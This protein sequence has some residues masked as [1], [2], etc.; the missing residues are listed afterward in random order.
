M[1]KQSSKYILLSIVVSS[2]SIVSTVLFQEPLKHAINKY[3]SKAAIS[4]D[5]ISVSSL[6]E[7][8]LQEYPK[9]EGINPFD[10]K[11]DDSIIDKYYVI[12]LKLSNKGVALTGNLKFLLSIGRNDVKII[13]IKHIVKNPV[14]KA[15][16]ISHSI[17]NLIWSLEKA[18][19]RTLTWDPPR[20]DIYGYKSTETDLAGFN[21]YRSKF[22]DAGYGKINDKLIQ[23][24]FFKIDSTIL[25]S[26]AYYA[27]EAVTALGG[28]S[29]L[30][31]SVK[32]PEGLAFSHHFK[33]VIIVDP[34]S[35]SKKQSNGSKMNKYISLSEAIKREGKKV[36]YLVED[37]RENIVNADNLVDN[38]NEN[39]KVLYLDD[40]KFFKGQAD[41]SFPSGL[42]EDAELYFYILFKTISETGYDTSLLLEGR[43]EVKVIKSNSSIQKNIHR[44]NEKSKDKLDKK[45]LLTPM[46][47]TAYVGKN[48]IYLMWEYPKDQKYKG[49]RIFRSEKR[50][51]HSYSLGEEIY[52]GTGNIDELFC[53]NIK[54]V[55]FRADSKVGTFDVPEE[56]PQ[57]QIKVPAAPNMLNAK[58]IF[59]GVNEKGGRHLPFFADNKVSPIKVYTYTLYAYDDNGINSYPIVINA[60]LRDLDSGLI[61]NTK[62][63]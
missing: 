35:K 56:P 39:I 38:K 21:V 29:D 60:S 44:D 49:V 33:D 18:S 51:N 61:C 31:N 63:K 25:Y 42:D 43:P 47:A 9:A 4:Y 16:A 6:K 58:Q 52:N 8:E 17:P 22:K 23:N 12:K 1:S 3:Y 30:S 50:D 10:L 15:I 28:R 27:S 19:E 45:Y 34:N 36:T 41:I 62:S 32:L 26:P 5:V 7:Q 53:K 14:H 11:L 24:T 54:A 59:G 46:L 37:Y 57:Q 40:L 13:D 55:I 20:T 2:I 48:N